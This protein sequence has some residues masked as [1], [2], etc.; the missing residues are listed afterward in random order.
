MLIIVHIET[1]GCDGL[2]R[3]RSLE[4]LALSGQQVEPGPVEGGGVA[5]WRSF[6]PPSR[7][8]AVT[9]PTKL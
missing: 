6:V 7:M 2:D 9:E 8:E 3:R 1:T 4:T 5:Q